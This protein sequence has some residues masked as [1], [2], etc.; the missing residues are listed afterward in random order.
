MSVSRYSLKPKTR[1]EERILEVCCA[2]VE[3]VIAAG[4]G[5]GDRIELCESL[6]V[7]GITPSGNLLKA[8][9]TASDLQ[10][11][12]LIRCRSGNFRFT[13]REVS[14][15][16]EQIEEMR[17]LGADGIVGGAL[18]DEGDIDEA[19]TS[20]FIQAAGPLPFTFHRAFDVLHDPLKGISRLRDLGVERILSS[21]GLSKVSEDPQRFR[22]LAVHAGERPVMLACG[23]IRSRNIRALAAM[24][25]IREFHS[26]ATGAGGGVEEGEVR[27]MKEAI[28]KES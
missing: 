14:S 26:A 28:M 21:A 13:G 19:A 16:V 25:E 5:G 6:E 24:R 2:S 22:Q 27:E 11:F 10:V 12:V 7:G 4:S 23:G 20:R 15:M 18:T 17:R 9:K 1:G 3:C 8:V